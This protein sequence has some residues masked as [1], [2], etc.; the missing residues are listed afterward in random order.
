M[1]TH[2]YTIASRDKSAAQAA[3]T[4]PSR[5][6]STYRQNSHINQNCFNFLTNNAIDFLQDLR[7]LKHVPH[8]QFTTG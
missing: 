4:D 7:S 2:K 6:N 8:I 1:N 3:G 5:C